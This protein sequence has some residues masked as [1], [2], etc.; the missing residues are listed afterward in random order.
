MT[1]NEVNELGEEDLERVL[2]PLYYQPYSLT[3]EDRNQR[4]IMRS[5]DLVCQDQEVLSTPSTLTRIQ[6][7]FRG[8]Y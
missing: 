2:E 1:A 5:I 6:A 8:N 3:I 7:L 4:I